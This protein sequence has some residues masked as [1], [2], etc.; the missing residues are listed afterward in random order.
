MRAQQTLSLR[1]RASQEAD[2][3]DLYQTRAPRQDI[4]QSEDHRLSRCHLILARRDLQ[5]LQK[6]RGHA[7]LCPCSVQSPPGCFEEYPQE[8]QQSSQHFVL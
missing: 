5:T 8:C 1:D 3:R 4:G 6:A 2:L 7:R